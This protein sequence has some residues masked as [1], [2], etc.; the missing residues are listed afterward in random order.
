MNAIDLTQKPPVVHHNCEGCDLCWCVCPTG[1]MDIPNIAVTQIAMRHIKGTGDLGA[2]LEVETKGKF[3]SLVKAED[4]GWDTPIYMNQNTPRIV[5]HDDGN[6][7]YC[8][9]QC[10][11]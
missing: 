5:V 3:R 7:D 4:V 6:T 11:L 8:Y 2:Q 10:K 1:A 9:K